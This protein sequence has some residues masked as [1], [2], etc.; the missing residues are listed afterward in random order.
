MKAR[1]PWRALFWRV[2]EWL[3]C[4]AG[5]ALLDAADWARERKHK[6]RRA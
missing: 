4:K 2:T 6:A 3:F 1:F 5:N